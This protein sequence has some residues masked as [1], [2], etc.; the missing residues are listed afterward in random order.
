MENLIPKTPDP[1]V[2]AITD[3]IGP[4]VTIAMLGYQEGGLNGDAL[5]VLCHVTEQL[6]AFALKHGAP[7]DPEAWD[8]IG[9]YLQQLTKQLD[10]EREVIDTL[11][12]LDAKGF[13]IYDEERGES[14]LHPQWADSPEEDILDALARSLG[15]AQ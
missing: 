3:R 12:D 9:D 4:L 7:T 2:E 8:F 6:V 15:D 1:V 10:A 11:H 14:Q 13:I 5:E